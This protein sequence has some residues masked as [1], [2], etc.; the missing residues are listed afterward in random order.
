M[1][2]IALEVTQ[3]ADGGYMAEHIEAAAVCWETN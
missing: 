1:N 2:E 3:E